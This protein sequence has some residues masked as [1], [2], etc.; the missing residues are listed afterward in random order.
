MGQV[1]RAPAFRLLLK[2]SDA[3]ALAPQHWPPHTL[4]FS[5]KRWTWPY[6]SMTTTPY[7]VGSST[8][9]EA[10]GVEEVGVQGQGVYGRGGNALSVEEC[11]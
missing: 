7:L 2:G 5:T 9:E 6:S 11:R 1:Q 3:S 8:W 10:R 4:G